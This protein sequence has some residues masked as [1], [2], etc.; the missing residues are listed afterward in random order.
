M[1][2]PG[3]NRLFGVLTMTEQRKAPPGNSG[4]QLTIPGPG[5]N[6]SYTPEMND[7]AKKLALLGL[8]DVEMAEFFGIC[9]KTFNNWKNKHPAFLQSINEGRVV[10]DAEVANSL[11]NRAK[12]EVVVVEKIVKNDDGKYEKVELKQF[13]PGEVQAQRLWLLNRRKHDWRDKQAMTHEGTIDHVHKVERVIVW[14]ES[15]D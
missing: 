4:N 13:V 5:R 1:G 10:A 9:E 7:Q 2:K 15:K 11:Y 3:I 6:S 14:P 8:I 12:G